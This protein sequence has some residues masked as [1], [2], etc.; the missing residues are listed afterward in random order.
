MTWIIF[1]LILLLT[2]VFGLFFGAY[3]SQTKTEFTD[4]ELRG[5]TNIESKIQEIKRKSVELFA[6][7][8]AAYSPSN[9]IEKQIFNQ[10][11]SYSYFDSSDGVD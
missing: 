2:F 9:D 3:F 7:K 4:D 6:G 8:R 11:E 10:E 1:G 5:H